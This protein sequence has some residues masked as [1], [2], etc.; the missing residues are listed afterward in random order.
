ME[1]STKKKCDT[2]SNLSEAGK[3]GIK[4]RLKIIAT[5]ALLLA[6]TNAMAGLVFLPGSIV[7]TNTELAPV[8]VQHL[9]DGSMRVHTTGLTGE[10]SLNISASG[11]DESPPHFNIATTEKVVLPF[12]QELELVINLF[13]GVVEGSSSGQ[14][15]NNTE[16]WD[17]IADVRG[18]A[19]CLP[20]N[21]RDC[22]QLIVTLELRGV[23]SDPN[24]PS[25][26]GQLRKE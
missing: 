7:H 12:D 18:N 5:S 15:I 8:S 22:G 2:G 17:F 9:D 6:A 14:Y 24:N 3:V 21:G 19:T 11:N 23:L 25:V 4:N 16:L 26:V 10:L 1:N 13:T 20:L